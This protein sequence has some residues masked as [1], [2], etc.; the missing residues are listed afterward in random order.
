MG[1]VGERKKSIIIG[2]T[3][4]TA[5]GGVVGFMAGGPAGAA[6]LTSMT[7]VA[8]AQAIEAFAGA[9]IFGAALL[10]ARSAMK[11]WFWNQKF[12]LL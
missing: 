2:T 10:G 3:C 9:T 4:V 8:A 12:I 1:H 11:T 6:V 5:A 7:S